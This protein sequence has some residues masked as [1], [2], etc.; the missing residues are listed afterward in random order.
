MYICVNYIHII[1]VI[2]WVHGCIYV[3]II[4]IF[5]VLIIFT[6]CAVDQFIVIH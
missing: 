5:H 3:L 2:F 1:A 6:F 4:F